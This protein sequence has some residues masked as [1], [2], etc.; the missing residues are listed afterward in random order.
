[1]NRTIKKLKIRVI[2][3]LITILF[4]L[5]ILIVHQ[6]FNEIILSSWASVKSVCKPQEALQDNIQ[7]V[8]STKQFNNGTIVVEYYIQQ[9]PKLT[10]HEQCHVSQLQRQYSFSASCDNKIQKFFSEVECNLA[11]NFPTQ[12]YE[13]VYGKLN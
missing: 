6:A 10:K 5:V 12:L 7:Q 8:A 9:T 11:E 3:S 2:Y 1:M 4:L 13:K